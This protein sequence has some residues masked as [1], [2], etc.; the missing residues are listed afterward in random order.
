MAVPASLSLA[1][2][3]ALSPGSSGKP[4]Q[5]RAG[6]AGGRELETDVIKGRRPSGDHG[7]RDTH[8]NNSGTNKSFRLGSVQDVK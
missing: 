8:L 7:D 3:E 5:Q 2:G 4:A 1:S 6:Q